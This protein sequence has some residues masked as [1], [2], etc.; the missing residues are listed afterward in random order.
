MKPARPPAGVRLALTV[1]QPASK[2]IDQLLGTGLYGRNRA[3]VAQRLLYQAL[4]GEEQALRAVEQVIARRR[5]G[6]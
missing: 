1:S 3:E 5:G 6:R 2:M 4:R